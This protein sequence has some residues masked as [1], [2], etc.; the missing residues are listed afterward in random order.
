VKGAQLPPKT[1]LNGRRSEIRLSEDHTMDV[2]TIGDH[3]LNLQLGS[4]GRI[5]PEIAGEAVAYGRR[6]VCKCHI[7]RILIDRPFFHLCAGDEVNIILQDKVGFD[8]Q[9]LSVVDY[10]LVYEWLKA[11]ELNAHLEGDADW[12]AVHHR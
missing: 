4:E 11:V 6:A 10:G 2:P 8:P 5:G 1:Q 3:T 12:E 9:L 7:E